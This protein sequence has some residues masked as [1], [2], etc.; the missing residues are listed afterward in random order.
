MQSGRGP[1]GGLQR[2]PDSETGAESGSGSGAGRGASGRRDADADVPRLLPQTCSDYCPLCPTEPPQP[3]P[4]TPETP[5]LPDTQTACQYLRRKM[6][7]QM[8]KEGLCVAVRSEP[9][10]LAVRSN[11]G[12]SSEINRRRKAS[13]RRKARICEKLGCVW[14]NVRGAGRCEDP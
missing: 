5:E 9:F 1:L 3:T 11:G 7:R 8:Q 6:W 10:C 13:S 14:R 12:S 2:Q 4:R